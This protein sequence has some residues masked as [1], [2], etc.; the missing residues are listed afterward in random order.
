MHVLKGL[1]VFLGICSGVCVAADIPYRTLPLLESTPQTIRPIPK[2]F[3]SHSLLPW[4]G[5]NEPPALL[6]MNHGK[7]FETRSL[8][9]RAEGRDG[10]NEMF[11]LPADYPVY[12]TGRPFAELAGAVYIPVPGKNGMFDLIHL[13]NWNYFINSGTVDSPAFKESYEIKFADGSPKDGAHWVAD[14]TGD[15]IP[16]LLTGGTTHPIQK[17]YMYPDYP[18]EKGPWSGEPHP[19]MGILPD[20]DIQN[21]RG[22]D[23]AGNWMGLPVRKYLW[24]AKGTRDEKGRLSFGNYREVRLGSTDYPVQWQCFGDKMPSAVIHLN[25]GL[26]IVVFS[27]NNLAYAMPVRG[28]VDG[29]LR[30]G[31]PEPLLADNGGMIPSVNHPN[32]I[33]VADMNMDGQEDIVVGSG[34]NGRFSILS[35][36]APG[37]FRDLGNIFC[38]GGPLAGDTLAVPVR[39]D[40]NR[41]G[42]PDVIIGGGSGELTLWCGTSDPLVYNSCRSFKTP[43]GWIRHRPVDGNL[44]GNNEVAWSYLQPQVFDWDGDG[45]LDFITNDN[46]AKLFLYRG[47]G[48]D[49]LLQERER[50]M[51]GDKPLP[52]AWRTRPAVIDGQYGVAGDDRPCLLFMKWDNT[53]AIG[54]PE[55]RG[56]LN[57]KK[58]IDLQDEDGFPVNI[59]G[60]AGLSGRAKVSVTDWDNDGKWDIVFGIQKSIQ[61]F[62]RKPDRESPT[63]A[64]F[65]MRNVGSNDHPVF[66]L[67]RMITFKDGTPICVNKHNFNVLPTDLDGDGL[68][69][70]IFGDDEGF[71]FYLYRKEL[72]WD[73]PIEKG[74]EMKKMIAAAAA[75]VAVYASGQTVFTEN[76]DYPAQPVSSKMAAGE[77]WAE[78]WQAEG[79]LVEVQDGKP[80]KGAFADC[81]SDG[82]VMLT[83]GGQSTASIK[84]QLAKPI[85]FNPDKETVFDISMVYARGDKTDNGGTE[86][87]NLF[88]LSPVSGKPICSFGTDSSEAITIRMGE[89]VAT[90][91]PK[92]T[93]YNGS[94]LVQAQLT[95][96]PAGQKDELCVRFIGDPARAKTSS[97]WDLKLEADLGGEAW[98]FQQALAKFAGTLMVDNLTMTVK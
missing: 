2:G 84:R 49:T 7:Y 32:V 12:D 56:S 46:E 10:R 86:T 36:D 4:F 1:G 37:R 59:C 55:K 27:G 18:K 78:G 5:T 24:W 63:A 13:G 74:R 53:F 9:Y 19:N 65:W 96:R 62:F 81:A 54:V 66:Q 92:K 88:V 31:K 47:T 43:S 87:V 90:S 41:D 83:G 8:I 51:S 34:G 50:F 91:D 70:I 40:W 44:Q 79:S 60:P 45:N 85:S 3:T 30:V 95:L 39:I 28:E 42:Y 29:E 67:P 23:I 48:P 16:D 98:Y 64:P 68:P 82:Y 20:T 21:F 6:V 97:K 80:P 73:E 52:I 75:T 57:I 69:D 77:G 76:W 33:G 61:R 17:F 22:Y 71:M 11:S 25:Q 38:H 89:E 93:D 26:Y 72:A 14:V 94:Y 15:G 58:I 35:G